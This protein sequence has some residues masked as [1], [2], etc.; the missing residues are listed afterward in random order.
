MEQQGGAGM[1]RKAFKKDMTPKTLTSQAHKGRL[2]PANPKWAREEVR[3]GY[4]QGGSDVRRRR[5]PDFC[6]D[7]SIPHHHEGSSLVLVN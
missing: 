4:L 2:S 5:R 7:L 1:P 3:E 6:H